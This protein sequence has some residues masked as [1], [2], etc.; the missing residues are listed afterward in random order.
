MRK[1]NVVRLGMASVAL[2]AM[3]WTA[4]AGQ[5]ASGVCAA[6]PAVNVPDAA[7]S[8]V[9]LRGCDTAPGHSSGAGATLSRPGA[10]CHPRTEGMR[11]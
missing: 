8:T 4:G 10:V 7:H 9:P 6:A 1:S 2:L 11:S 3:T 5:A